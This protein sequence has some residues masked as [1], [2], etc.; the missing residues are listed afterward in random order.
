MC[1]FISRLSILFL[2]SLFHF[3]MTVQYY[4]YD[5]SFVVYSEVREPDSFSSVFLCQDSFGYSGSFM[6]PYNLWIF[7]CPTSVRNAIGNLIEIAWDL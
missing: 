7:F 2:W 3:L 6:F 5:C 1:K 4:F